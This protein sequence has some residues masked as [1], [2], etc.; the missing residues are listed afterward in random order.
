VTGT[1]WSSALADPAGLRANGLF[2][3]EGRL[4]L[5]RILAG[6]AG[7]DAA[8]VAVLSTPAAAHA[9]DLGA[10]VSDRLTTRSPAE[11]ATLTGFNFHRGVLALV[12]RPPALDASVVADAAVRATARSRRPDRASG[13]AH[14]ADAMASDGQGAVLVVAEQLVD[15]DNVGSCFRNAQAF[16]AAGMLLDDRCP[17][18]LYRKAVRTSL[19]AVLDLPWAQAPI[20]GLMDALAVAGVAA[21]GL[22]PHHGAPIAEVAA[23]LAPHLPVAL[24]VGNEGHG[25]SAATRA[26]C[27]RLARIPMADGA[28]SLNVATALAVALY[29]W[30]VRQP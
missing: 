16:G 27:A 29:A 23:E 5:E 22:V 9:L 7:G 26:R 30:R 11:M 14:T 24:V 17:D 1:Q 20:G 8:I 3:A 28:D 12:R 2:L 10:R 15:V 6:A 4:V 21:V 13:P 18:P 25:L 19:G